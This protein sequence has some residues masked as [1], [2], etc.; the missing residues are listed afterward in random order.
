MTSNSSPADPERRG[1]I[2]RFAAVVLG[3]IVTVVPAA[4]G[5]IVLL[6]P[7]KRKGRSGT[8]DG[9]DFVYVTA[10][11][12]LPA[13]GVPRQFPIVK[14]RKDAWTTH[15]QVPVGA[16]FL[17]RHADS[18]VSAFNV[19]CPHLGCMVSFQPNAGSFLCPCHDSSFRIDGS[20]ENPDSP[21][22]RGMDA[23]EVEI[24]DEKEIWVRFENF[25]AGTKS[26]ISVS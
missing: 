26:K 1:F 9:A 14:N 8:A 4:A 3:A 10:L 16:V 17:L 15:P 22:P 5:L 23:L 2:K 13:D 6:D 11:A 24:R 18:G 12:A 19:V 25:L 20:I 7:L 21:S